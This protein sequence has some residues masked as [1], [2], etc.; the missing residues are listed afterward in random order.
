MDVRGS[1]TGGAAEANC[2]H[3]T[4]YIKSDPPAKVCAG[5]MFL[6]VDRSWY[7]GV[8]FSRCS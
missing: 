3:S 4:N 2:H 7:H 6:G 1:I 8:Y 5:V